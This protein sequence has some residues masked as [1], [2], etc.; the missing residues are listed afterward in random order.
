MKKN[1]IIEDRGIYDEN[2]N[3]VCVFPLCET[4]QEKAERKQNMINI[5]NFLNTEKVSHTVKCPTA[6][7]KME[8]YK[9]TDGAS[10]YISHDIDGITN[11]LE[12]MSLGEKYTVSF[13]EMEEKDYAELSEFDG[14]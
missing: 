5:L 12:N 13:E 8:V 10:T 6:K 11:E 3:E 2:M 1:Y 7:G 9:L 4:D 14:W